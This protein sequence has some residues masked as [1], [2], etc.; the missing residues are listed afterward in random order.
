ML[1]LPLEFQPKRR[2]LEQHLLDNPQDATKLAIAHFE[3]FLALTIKFKDLQSQVKEQSAFS[4]DLSLNFRLPLHLQL[5][6]DKLRRYLKQYPDEAQE[7]AIDHYE[8]FIN[9]LIEYKLLLSNN[10]HSS[11]TL[12]SFISNN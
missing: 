3:D 12:P 1:S 10:R 2:K 8:D 11:L 9:L 5:E 4:S 6:V 7:L